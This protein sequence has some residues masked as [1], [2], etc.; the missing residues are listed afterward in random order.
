MEIRWTRNREHFLQYRSETWGITLYFRIYIFKCKMN[1]MIYLFS[2]FL[3]KRRECLKCLP[4]PL[5]HPPPTRK[6]YIEYIFLSI[7][8]HTYKGSYVRNC[9]PS[10]LTRNHWCIE[11]E[12]IDRRKSQFHS[13]LVYV[14]T[15]SRSAWA[16]IM[17][18]WGNIWEKLTE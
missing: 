2:S 3:I 12:N 10:S 6:N 11:N 16:K 1:I 14:F 5:H 13:N 15:R 17:I 9:H 8:T 7:Y 18:E 4:S